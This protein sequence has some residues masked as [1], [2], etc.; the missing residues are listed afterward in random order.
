MQGKWKLLA[1]GGKPVELFDLESDPNEHENV[2][3]RNP[4]LVASLTTELNEWLE[5]PRTPRECKP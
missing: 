5:A 2:I 3:E 4:D 1:L